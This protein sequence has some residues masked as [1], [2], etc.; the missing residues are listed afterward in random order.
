MSETNQPSYRYAIKQ[1]CNN[2]SQG[3]L[4]MVTLSGVSGRNDPLRNI[5]NVELLIGQDN[6]INAI[7]VD[8]D[9]VIERSRSV[10]ADSG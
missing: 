3:K 2:D 7:N 10:S 1:V 9:C 4:A 6:E 8:G 5:R